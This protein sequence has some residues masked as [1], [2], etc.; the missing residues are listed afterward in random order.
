MTRSRS[1]AAG[2]FLLELD[3]VAAGFLKSVAGGAIAADVVSRP[4]QAYYDE[5][6]V[7]ALRYEPLALRLD[8]SLAHAVYDWIADTWRGKAQRHDVSI[9]AVSAQLK[10]VS[11][12][13]FFRALLTEATIPAADAAAKDPAFLA[14]KLVPEDIRA[15]KGSGATVKTPASK[16]KTFLPSNFKLAI[17]KLDCSRVSKIDSFTVKQTAAPQ[18]GGEV[19][20][21]RREPSRVEFPNLRISLAESSA[22]TWSAWFDDFV[23]KGNNDATKERSGTLS[24]LTPDQKS[25]LAEIKLF[26]LGIFR[27]APEP[28]AA[29]AEQIAR[30]QADLY[31]ER[32]ELKVG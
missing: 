21:A 19:R 1:V 5:K 22:Q 10:A 4:G 17:D 26:N 15:A 31:C 18:A 32:M 16:Q 29:A 24:F 28:Q 12:R 23:V 27:L 6:H 7:A 11:E 9:V 3:G 8:L 13:R 25:V 14:V 30:L 2:R 20:V